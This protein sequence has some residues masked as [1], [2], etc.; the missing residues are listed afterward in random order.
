M[1]RG[2]APSLSNPPSILPDGIWTEQE[3]DE[4]VWL[5]AYGMGGVQWWGLQGCTG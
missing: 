3:E 1:A 2:K 4:G 5:G